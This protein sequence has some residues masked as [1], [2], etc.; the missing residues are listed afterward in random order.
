MRRAGR[1]VAG[2]LAAVGR[3]IAPGVTTAELDACATV[4]V[5]ARGGRMAFKEYRGYPANICVSVNEEVVH[6]I[7]G[8]RRLRAGDIVSVDI[9]VFC[10]NYCSD[11]AQTFAVGEVSEEAR[12]LMA[13]TREALGAAIAV[14]RPGG[15]LSEVSEAVQRHVEGAGFSV[16]R[17]FVGHGI[18]SRMH[19]DPQV[20]NYVDAEVRRNDL[21]LQPGIV[22][23]IEPMVN[24]GGCDVEVLAD[25]WTVVTKDRRLSAH[26]EHTVALGAD[27]PDVL[28][29]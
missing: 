13:V 9:G 14:V 7:P 27:G 19:E 12:R 3:K 26:F 28:T 5:T 8:P 16:V 20:P 11:A 17:K 10:D 23:A 29:A 21:V 18:G 24:A 4:H 1:I 6:G 22:L 2:A 25:A 15:R